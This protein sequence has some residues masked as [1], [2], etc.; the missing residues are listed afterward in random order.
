M[1]NGFENKAGISKYVEFAFTEAKA[2]SKDKQDGKERELSWQL[3]PMPMVSNI[4]ND[5]QLLALH[6]V[7][8]H[9]SAVLEF[10]AFLI[11]CS[12]WLFATHDEA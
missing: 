9:L 3:P 10:G 7:S 8:L 5:L 2:V 4:T 1:L 11:R 12:D 6:G